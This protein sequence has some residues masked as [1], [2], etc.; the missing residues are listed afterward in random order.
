[1]TILFPGD[2]GHEPSLEPPEQEPAPRCPACGSDE[3]S[4]FY[5][6]RWGRI[7]GC[8]APGCVETRDPWE[9]PV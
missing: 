7:C 8:D 9:M 3:G 6:D 1:M 2:I 4:V 5:V